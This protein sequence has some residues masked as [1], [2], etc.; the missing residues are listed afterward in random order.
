MKTDGIYS[1]ALEIHILTAVIAKKTVHALRQRLD[2]AD[3]GTSGLQ[4][5]I[6]RALDCR[7]Q[8]ISKL[9][10]HFMLDP[11]TLVPAV[12]ALERKGFATRGRDPN[13]C[14]RVPLSLTARGRVC[15][16]RPL[17]G[18]RRPSSAKPQRLGR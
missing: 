13:D 9:S 15:G 16:V 11:S 3:A 7:E 2:M 18:R 8:T 14:R 17:A 12:D 1:T 5:K 10:H 4:Y 6:L